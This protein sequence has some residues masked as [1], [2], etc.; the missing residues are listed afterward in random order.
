M[1]DKASNTSDG[2][3]VAERSSSFRVARSAEGGSGVG[4][5]TRRRPPYAAKIPNE[6]SLEAIEQTRTKE[7]LA[8]FESVEEMIASLNDE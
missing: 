6:A 5:R 8:G 2:L 7:G 3:G 4:K 1:A